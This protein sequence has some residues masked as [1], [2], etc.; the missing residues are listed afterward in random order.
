MP[1]L[2]D[3]TQCDV[4]GVWPDR[5]LR[6]VSGVSLKPVFDGESLGDERPIYLLFSKDRGLRQGD[7]TVVSFQGTDWELYNVAEDRAE[8]NDLSQTYPDRLDAMVAT[9]TAIT[10]EVIHAPARTY[11]PVTEAK[12][13]HRHREWTNFDSTKP[14]ARQQNKGKPNNGGIRARKNTSLTIDN[15]TLALKLKFTG[16]DPGIA[17]DLTKQPISNGPYRLSFDLIHGVK[18]A[19][20]VGAV[21]KCSTPPTQ[22]RH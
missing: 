15:K 14:P 13:S 6:P 5:D 4:T 2:A 17:M 10:E 18:L 21:A 1:T 20:G 3:V 19:D 11:A 9:W 22:R 16:D 7:W 8:L 12:R